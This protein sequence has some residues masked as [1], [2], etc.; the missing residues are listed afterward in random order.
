[1]S[2]AVRNRFRM[3]IDELVRR[4][5]FRVIG[6]YVV[7]AFAALQGAD[8][9][10]PA[11]HLPAWTMTLLVVAALVGSPVAIGLAWVFDIV[12]GGIQRTARLAD[13]RRW[14]QAGGAVTWGEVAPGYGRPS[15][16]AALPAEAFRPGPAEQRVAL[17][18]PEAT[19]ATP[20]V[21]VM[22]FVN[23]SPDPE[24][25]YFADGITE[26]VIAQLSRIGALKVISRESVMAF[27]KR[28]QSLREIGARLG[29]TILLDGSVR[30]AAD[31]VR[32]VARLIDARTEEHLWAET[33][34]RQLTDI[35]AIQTDVALHIAAALRAELS[36]DERT[37]LGKEPTSNLQAYQLYQQ[38]RH[39]YI[40]F[41]PEGMQ[42]AI[43]L[44]GKAVAEDPSYALAF[45]GIS[46]CYANLAETGA[47]PTA[48][49]RTCATDAA[50]EALRLDL[51][52]GEAHSA[53]AQLKSLWEFDW[54][55]AE[56]GFRRALE[57]CPSSAD[58]M[59]LYGRLCS[60]LARFDE[61]LALQRRARDLDPLAHRLDVATTLLRAGRY[62]EA[63]Q[64]VARALEFDP[65]YDRVHA[66]LGWLHLL[67]GRSDEGVREIERAVAL[68][69]ADTQWQA[70]LGQALAQ[71]GR[72]DEA[73]AILRRLEERA[74][75]DFVSP[76]HLVF[77]Y[78]GLGEHER[79]LDLLERAFEE[80]AGAIYGIKGSF[81][82]APLRP[83]PRFQALLARMNVA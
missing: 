80:R 18:S 55:G 37:R 78:T 15:A 74:A 70:Q 47:L 82:L 22:P 65:D 41:T 33:Y 40:H 53:M 46:L 56:A 26:D 58:T 38:A 35:F 71:V 64:E 21:A 63:A 20:A 83:H 66:T 2:S 77:V 17:P 5:V 81:L 42:R 51:G 45:V 25:E 27:K 6:I 54:A 57:L 43:E 59:D 49:A 50:A 34:D 10:V 30:R 44:L 48:I 16:P 13:E 12:P 1:M 39:W 11:L 68:S 36:V 73:R 69:P 23:L 7:G 28:E 29:V 72:T 31:R 76:Y 79:A 14:E 19:H 67:Q 3:L 32:I 8:I 9:L 24:N 4:R 75:T 52:L 60:A 62:E 61:A